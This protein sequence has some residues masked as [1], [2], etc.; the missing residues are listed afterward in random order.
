MVTNRSHA[1]VT[2][3]HAQLPSFLSGVTQSSHDCAFVAPQGTC[4]LSFT[5]TQPYIPQNLAIV[6]SNTSNP[7]DRIALVFSMNGYLVYNV[8][9]TSRMVYVVDNTNLTGSAWGRSPYW[10]STEYSRSPSTIAWAQFFTFGAGK[11]TDGSKR[12]LFGV[13]CVQGFN[14]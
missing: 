1:T 4:T 2:N 9:T 8:D 6:G 13:R 11:Q 12:N 5:S 14:Y 3:V 7:I 10:S